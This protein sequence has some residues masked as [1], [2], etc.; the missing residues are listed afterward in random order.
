[1]SDDE[2]AIEKKKKNKKILTGRIVIICMKIARV[3]SDVMII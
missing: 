3:N 2:Y 1:M